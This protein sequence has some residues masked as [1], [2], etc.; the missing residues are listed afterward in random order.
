VLT[1][2]YRFDI[3]DF[4]KNKFLSFWQSIGL[5]LA[6][7]TIIGGI[8]TERIGRVLAES[9]MSKPKVIFLVK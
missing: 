8:R 7:L 9:L 5:L 2:K 6:V 3:L 1:L 4:E